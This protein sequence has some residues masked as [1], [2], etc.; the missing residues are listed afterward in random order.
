MLNIFIFIKII[1]FFGMRKNSLKCR[2]GN[3]N[4]VSSAAIA[5]FIKKVVLT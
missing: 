4:F 5:Y 3:V 2:N 1:Q